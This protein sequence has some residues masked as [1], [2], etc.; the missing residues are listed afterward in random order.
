MR[1]AFR[2]LVLIAGILL[3]GGTIGTASGANVELGWKVHSPDDMPLSGV[4]IS[5]DGSKVFVGGSH[6]LVISRHGKIQWGGWA[7]GIAAMSADGNY[8]VTALGEH[9][10]LLDNNGVELWTRSMGTPI[11][12]VDISPNG[13]LIV[14]ADNRGTLQS[15][16]P[17]GE[18]GGVALI[19]PAKNVMISPQG[20]LIVIASEAGLRY[21]TPGMTTT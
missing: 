18:S 6:L 20:N 9:L 2:I 3:I 17:S 19:E 12:A 10:R 7:G 16:N 11:R 5:S 13:S 4:T 15:W 8:V 1:A 21:V 14:S